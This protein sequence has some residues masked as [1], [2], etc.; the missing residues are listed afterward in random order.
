MGEIWLGVWWF[1]RV[2]VVVW[3]GSWADSLAFVEFFRR[4]LDV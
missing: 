4:L 2:L 3:S 1:L